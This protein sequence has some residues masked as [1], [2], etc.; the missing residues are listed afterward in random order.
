MIPIRFGNP[1]RE[2]AGIYQPARANAGP[3]GCALI[4]NPFGQEAIRF[5]RMFRVLADRLARTGMHVLRFDYFGTGDSGG[6]DEQGDFEG[7]IGDVLMANAELIR[8]S[9]AAPCAWFGVR[10]GASL[11]AIAS[12]RPGQ[13]PDR[14]VLWDPVIDGTAYLAELAEAHVDAAKAGYGMRWTLESRLR[15]MVTAE[16]ATAALGFPLT[17]LLK[18]QLGNLA[19]P[20]FKAAGAGQVALFADRRGAEVRA[21]QQQLAAVGVDVSVTPL[22]TGIDWMTNEALNSAIV[23]MQALEAIV[24]ALLGKP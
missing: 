24:Q 18:K 12:G 5:H 6:D 4:C 22:Q 10:L 3:A 9:G 23:P 2:L 7:W 15:D 20:A 19:L 21:L 11:A 16:L 8:R 17:E 13:S 1:A 14:L